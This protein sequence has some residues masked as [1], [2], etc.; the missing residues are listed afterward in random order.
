MFQ[1]MI[2]HPNEAETLL[3]LVDEYENDRGKNS[4]F[5]DPLPRENDLDLEEDSLPLVKKV[6]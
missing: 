5:V 3:R 6:R 4:E 1:M 2:H